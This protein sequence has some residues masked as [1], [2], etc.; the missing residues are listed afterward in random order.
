MCARCRREGMVIPKRFTQPLTSNTYINNDASLDQEKNSDMKLVLSH[1]FYCMPCGQG[2]QMFT[3]DQGTLRQSY[4]CDKNYNYC[5]SNSMYDP[6][7]S[8]YFTEKQTFQ[9]KCWAAALVILTF[10]VTTRKKRKI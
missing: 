2:I 7:F 9:L 8:P 6:D 10:V 5:G 3:N 1:L 4:N